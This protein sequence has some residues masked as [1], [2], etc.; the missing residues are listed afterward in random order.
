[1]ITTIAQFKLAK[2]TTIEEARQMFLQSAP[3]YQSAEG[4]VRKYYILAEGGESA[5]AVYLWETL[6]AA[7]KVHTQEWRKKLLDK[8]GS[9]P[10][11][12][13]FHSPLIVDNNLGIIIN[14]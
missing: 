5:G 12:Y 11:L 3:E 13:Y 1:M 10:A 6:D 14:G 2:P 4:L 7:K 9:E 8:Y